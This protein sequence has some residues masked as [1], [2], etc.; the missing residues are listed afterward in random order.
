MKTTA[1]LHVDFMCLINGHSK[2]LAEKS[3]VTRY[4]QYVDDFI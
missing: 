3:K 1:K 2:I 4:C